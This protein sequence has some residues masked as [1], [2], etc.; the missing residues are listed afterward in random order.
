MTLRRSLA[1]VL[2]VGSL[3]LAGACAGDDLDAT[4]G[5]RRDD[6]AAGGARSRSPAR[7]SPRPRWWPRCTSCCWPTPA[8]RPTVK[9]VDTRDV[10]M[11]TFPG[12]ID[13]VPEYVGGIVNFLNTTE[14]GADAK[15]FDGR[16]RQASRRHG[17]PARATRA[18]PCSSP[19]R[20]PTPTPSSSP[21]STPRPRA[22]PRCP[23]SRARPSRSPPR[24]TARAG[25]T[26]RAACPSS[27][28]HRHQEV[29][30]LGLRQRPDLPVGD[31]RRVPARPD[32]H[33]RRH[34]REPGPGRARGRPA[35]PAGAEPR[36]RRS[37]PSSST[38]TPTS[39]TSSTR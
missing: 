22:S 37:A 33:H 2:A 30:P 35:D 28:R 13:V 10:Y 8:T 36:A 12:D 17:G 26:A 4:R 38:S 9:L 14:N 1:A 11:P 16:R 29:L 7:P 18:S 32:Q 24:P 20:R 27:L 34:P 39:P 15:P 5:H 31:R 6:A 23:T 19:R 21:R 3:L 25:P